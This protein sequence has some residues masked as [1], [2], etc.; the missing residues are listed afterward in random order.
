M[1]LVSGRHSLGYITTFLFL[2]VRADLL[3]ALS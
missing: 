2:K 3:S 1:L